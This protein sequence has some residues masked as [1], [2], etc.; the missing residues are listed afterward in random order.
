M[1]TRQV[2]MMSFEEDSQCLLAKDFE[3]KLP[4]GSSLPTIP[5]PAIS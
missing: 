1:P 2:S 3:E 4:S 5:L